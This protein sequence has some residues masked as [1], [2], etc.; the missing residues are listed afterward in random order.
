MSV[1][2]GKR[3]I[4]KLTI[5][6]EGEKLLQYIIDVTVK[7]YLPPTHEDNISSQSKIVEYA[8]AKWFAECMRSEMLSCLSNIQAANKIVVLDEESYHE[9]RLCQTQAE[10]CVEKV[11]TASTLMYRKKLIKSKRIKFIGQQIYHIKRML[12][13]WRKSDKARYTNREQ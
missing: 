13:N 12:Q 6:T 11:L 4:G 9:R 10:R 8:N 7:Y 1:P 2:E 5:E 3:K